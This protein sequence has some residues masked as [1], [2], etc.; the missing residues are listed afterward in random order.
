[1]PPPDVPPGG[2]APLDSRTAR[3]HTL[4]MSGGFRRRVSRGA[5][6]SMAVVGMTALLTLGCAHAPPRFDPQARRTCL[7][8]S[9]GGTRGVAE[10]GG[11]A[12]VR[13]ASLPIDCVVGTSVGALVGA[14]YASAPEQDTT[15]R[16][17]RLTE[18]YVAETEREAASRGVGAGLALAAVASVFSGGMLAPA[19]AA[20]G[21]Y[22]LG[23]GPRRAPIGG[24]SSRCCARSWAA[25]GSR[26]CPNRSRRCTTSG[27]ARGCAW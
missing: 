10:L 21:G 2:L 5:A 3:R 17:R 15:A 8:L 23:A 9:S 7:V 25:R 26:R 1:M 20:V 22:L 27:P 6:L 19:T 12:A 4:A 24:A 16:F 13:Q 18:A 14:L 11:V